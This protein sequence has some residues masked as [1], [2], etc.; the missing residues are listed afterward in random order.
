[1][2]ASKNLSRLILKFFSWKLIKKFFFNFSKISEL[3]N[4]SRWANIGFP[5]NF[6]RLLCERW[7][8]SRIRFP[9]NTIFISAFDTRRRAKFICNTNRFQF[10]EPINLVRVSRSDTMKTYRNC[11]H[12][13]SF[14]IN[15]VQFFLLENSNIF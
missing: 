2:E 5:L 4:K 12:K 10:I 6:L 7:S 13:F 11:N 8:I 15:Q 9:C 1:M 3:E 14:N